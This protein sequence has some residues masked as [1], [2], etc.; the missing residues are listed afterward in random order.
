MRGSSSK[1]VQKLP[2][3]VKKHENSQLFQY[4]GHSEETFDHE[5]GIF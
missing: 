3:I 5:I 4:L 2:N 1:I